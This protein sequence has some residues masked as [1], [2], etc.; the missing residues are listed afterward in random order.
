MKKNLIA[1][2]FLLSLC[3]CDFIC[4]EPE[5]EKDKVSLPDSTKVSL[6]VH[7]WHPVKP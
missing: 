1:L 7:L 5:D 3:S 4:P 6:K 2:V